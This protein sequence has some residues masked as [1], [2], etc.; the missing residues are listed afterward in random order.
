MTSRGLGPGKL[1]TSAINEEYYG[2]MFTCLIS[3]I[4]A[5]KKTDTEKKKQD[6]DQMK[7]KYGLSTPENK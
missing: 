3:S 4:Q 5:F 1:R 6:L 2:I 7:S